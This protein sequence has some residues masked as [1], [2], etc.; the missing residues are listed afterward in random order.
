M[1]VGLPAGVRRT[2]REDA[3]PLGPAGG[4]VIVTVIS[5]GDEAKESVFGLAAGGISTRYGANKSKSRLPWP[6]STTTLAG[7]AEVA[8]VALSRKQVFN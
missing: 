1:T 6:P 5:V 8:T 3:T 7:S 4:V 2:V